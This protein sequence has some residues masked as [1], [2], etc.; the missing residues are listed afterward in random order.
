MITLFFV[1]KLFN[2][3]KK[4]FHFDT[5]IGLVEQ[6]LITPTVAKLLSQKI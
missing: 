2:T 1:I 6:F 4:T 3:A 5:T